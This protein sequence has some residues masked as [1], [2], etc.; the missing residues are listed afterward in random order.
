[1][2]TRKKNLRKIEKSDKEEED[3]LNEIRM[4][5]QEARE[6]KDEIEASTRELVSQMLNYIVL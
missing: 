5:I 4:E 2:T 3:E 6:G 1:M